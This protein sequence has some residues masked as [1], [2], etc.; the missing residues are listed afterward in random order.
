MAQSGQTLPQVSANGGTIDGV[1]HV[2]TTDGAGPVQAVIDP[3]AS[4]TFSAGTQANVV[5]GKTPLFCVGFTPF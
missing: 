3:T 5:T 1:F 4:G 2:V